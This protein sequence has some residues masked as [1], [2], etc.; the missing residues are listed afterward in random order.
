[1]QNTKSALP[2]KADMCST[3]GDVY[4]GP[5]TDICSAA[6]FVRW[7]KME[8]EARWLSTTALSTPIVMLAARQQ[9]S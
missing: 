7:A 9:K 3:L 4:Y 8:L 2:S 1:V 5:E 6:A